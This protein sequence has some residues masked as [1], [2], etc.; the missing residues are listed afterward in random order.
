MWT[1]AFALLVS[2]GCCFASTLTLNT[3]DHALVTLVTGV[4][5]GYAHGAMALASS[6]A[7]T[8]GNMSLV[9]MITPE[10]PS[11]HVKMLEK[12]WRVERVDPVACN[13]KLGSTVSEATH[14]LNGEG[15]K[16]GIMRW[17]H[18]CTKFRAW[19]LTKFKRVVFMDSDMLV[20]GP[21]DHALYGYSNASF[22]AA[23]ETFPPDNFN[24][25]FMVITP[26]EDMFSKLLGINQVVGSAEGGDQGVLNNGLCPQWFT[27][28]RD[29][30]DCGRL[31]WIF[32]VEVI[33]YKQYE[34]LQ[35]MS[36]RPLPAVIHF[37][38]DGKPWTI[39]AADYADEKPPG[40]DDAKAKLIPLTYAHALWRVHFFKA[41]G[42]TPPK[43]S[44]FGEEMDLL[45]NSENRAS[46]S[47]AIQDKANVK[48]Q[49]DRQEDQAPDYDDF[50]EKST[51]HSV[52]QHSTIT[53]KDQ[54]NNAV[55]VGKQ[56]GKRPTRVGK[57]L[58]KRHRRHD[59]TDDTEL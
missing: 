10:V 31:P 9:V 53:D 13:H 20:I 22:V 35:K 4:D 19:Q 36:S 55:K 46:S 7:S 8:N 34:T 39:L 14:D 1:I 30:P 21:I 29:D 24:A 56:R 38:S 27:A 43:R 16:A 25:G 18:T 23:P 47:Q 52:R 40:L 42:Y 51:S 54:G 33:H 15:Y 17:K 59:I 26:S 32:N 50:N 6:Y 41:T 58:K 45:F 57:V 49:T 28:D 12:L 37:V 11:D 5:G 3:R 48:Q 44:L 2:F